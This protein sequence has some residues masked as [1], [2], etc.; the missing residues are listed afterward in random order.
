MIEVYMDDMLIKSSVEGLHEEQYGERV[1]KG[2]T[3]QY[4]AQS[5]KTNPQI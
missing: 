3:I 1:L 5:R 4:E 2:S